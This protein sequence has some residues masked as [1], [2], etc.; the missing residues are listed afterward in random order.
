MTVFKS[1][2]PRGVPVVCLR[3]LRGIS[4][5]EDLGTKCPICGAVFKRVK[6]VGTDGKIVEKGG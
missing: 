6:L 4:R 3:V 5:R 2:I 1:R